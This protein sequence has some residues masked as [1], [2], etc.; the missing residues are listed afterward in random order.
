MHEWREPNVKKNT[1]IRDIS[2]QAGVS[3]ATVSRFLN[4]SYTNMSEETRHKLE[5]IV[6][7]LDY[8]PNNLARG[9][10][11]QNSHM[12][13]CVVADMENPFS[14]LLIK[15][16]QSVCRPHGYKL[17]ILD[18]ENDPQIE[19][20]A[21]QTMLDTPV[22]GIICNTTGFAIREIEAAS[23]RAPIVLADRLF[24]T[25]KEFD[26]VSSDDADATFECLRYLRS[27]GYERVA[28]FSPPVDGISTRTERL[29]AFRKGVSAFFECSAEEYIYNIRLNSPEETVPALLAFAGKSKTIP[30]ALFSVNGTVTL[31]LIR[32]AKLCGLRFSSDLGLCGFDDWPWMELVEQGITSI[33]TDT[34][35]MGAKC[36]EL[37]FERITNGSSTPFRRIVMQNHRTDR[38]STDRHNR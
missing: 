20:E 8:H 17:L 31:H 21:Y 4:G 18:A 36:A 30:S 5:R 7:E 27:Q 6:R 38:S 37:L 1:T 13:G 29:A 19:K 24:P 10:K 15:G 26:S 11:S 23:E 28:F 14:A 3:I 16:I 35:A 9:L 25:E 22:E 33:S 34:V 12:I 32:A 2:V